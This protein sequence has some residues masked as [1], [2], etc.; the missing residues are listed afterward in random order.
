MSRKMLIVE[1]DENISELFS[2]YMEREGFQTA[3]ARD[4]E[5][6]LSL[7]GVLSRYNPARCYAPQA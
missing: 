3:T 6:A 5:E 7:Q 4:G 1:D 2:L